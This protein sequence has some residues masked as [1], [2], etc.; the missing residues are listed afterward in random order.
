MKEKIR[1]CFNSAWETYDKHCA[2]QRKICKDCIDLIPCFGN[3]FNTIADFACGT[4]ISTQHL[5]TH[6][7]YKTC[8][9]IDIAENLLAI[10]NEKLINKDIKFILSDFDNPVFGEN[11]LDLIF[12][13]MGLQ[14]SLDLEATLNLFNFYLNKSGLMIFSIPIEGN[15]PEIKK[16]HK[17]AMHKIE[18]VKKILEKTHFKVLR[19]CKKT[20]VEKFNSPHHALSSIKAIGANCLFSPKENKLLGLSRNHMIKSNQPTLTYQVAIFMA[21]AGLDAVQ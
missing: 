11:Y 6:V 15:F 8:Y 12:C 16:P 19:F 20:Y 13:N 10:A 18:V 14:W 7:K 21:M 3:Y 1:S 4:G 17:N 9:A 2:V 5:V